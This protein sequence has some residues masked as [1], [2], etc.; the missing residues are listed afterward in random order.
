MNILVFGGHGTIG[1]PLVKMLEE[2]HTIYNPTHKE[3][4][5]LDYN[6]LNDAFYYPSLS[7]EEKPDLI[8]NLAAKE[9]N[10]SLNKTNPVDIYR[11][12]V[13][14]GLNVFETCRIHKIPRLI[15]CV[16]SCSYGEAE[17]LK[18]ANFDKTPPNETVLPHAHAKRQL[19]YMAQFYRQQYGLMTQTLCFNNVYGCIPL[20]IIK[21]S[22]S[23]ATFDTQ[24]L[25]VL[26]ALFVKIL[27][28]REE[29]EKEIE[30]WGTGKPLREFV[31]YEDVA[32]AI[33]DIVN[34]GGAF[35]HI[36]N[37]FKNVELMN[38]G[39][40]QEISIADLV[41]TMK[42]HF[43]YKGKLKFDRNKPDGQMRKLLDSSKFRSFF[44]NFK[45]TSMQDGIDKMLKTYAV[46]VWQDVHDDVYKLVDK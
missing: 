35:P 39:S 29:N 19:Y 45:F 11:D 7:V 44:P 30:I 38:I 37:K 24:T 16:C 10:I 21:H 12:T 41:K 3:L 36:Y 2:N 14:M 18:E 34:L 25:K 22:T 26:D 17:L 31:Y 9:T 28:S 4:D 42:D 6:E 20:S 27:K 15:Q 23:P 32:C 33:D 1:I 40:Q 13:Q 8:I 43:G 46:D 5:L